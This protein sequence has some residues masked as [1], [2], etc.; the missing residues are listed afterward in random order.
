M[1]IVEQLW[2]HVILVRPPA[3]NRW[4]LLGDKSMIVVAKIIMK[5]RTFK[6]L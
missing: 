3:G 4:N 6:N 1:E 2:I 5:F